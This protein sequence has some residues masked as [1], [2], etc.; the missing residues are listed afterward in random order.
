[1]DVAKELLAGTVLAGA[2]AIRW[3]DDNDP[4]GADVLASVFADTGRAHIVG[5]TGPPGAGK[6][7]LVSALIAEERKRGRRVGVIAVDPSSPF[8]GGAILGDRV[9]MSRHT[10]D[11]DVFIR[12]VGSRGQ[13]GGLARSTHDAC[14]ILDAMGYDVIFVETMGVGQDEIDIVA[15]AH[16]TVIVGVPGLGDEV[17]AVKAGLMEAGEIFVINKADR[18]GYEATQKQLE[19]M[20][21]LRAESRGYK[22]DDWSPPLLPAVALKDEGIAAIVDAIDQH[23]ERLRA[24]GDFERRTGQRERE[25]TLTLLREEIMRSITGSADPAV[26]AAVERREL[27]PHTAARSLLDQWRRKNMP[28]LNDTNDS[29]V[30]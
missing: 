21:H 8:T 10:L 11:P 20:L 13:V 25:H 30:L 27:D 5:V 12:S 22:D 14:L 17:Q 2:R 16:T 3:L 23:G 15:L 26:M 28:G 18:E 19:L 29:E 4:R 7:T 6:S 1:M 24:S 9:R